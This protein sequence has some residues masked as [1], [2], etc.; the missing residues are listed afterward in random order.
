VTRPTL[1]QVDFYCRQAH[2]KVDALT[3]YL[4]YEQ[5]GW[6][7]GKTPMKNWRAAVAL[8]DRTQQLRREAL[9]V[10]KRDQEFAAAIKRSRED[11]RPDEGLFQF[12]TR[13]GA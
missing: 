6:F 11:D 9:N 2:P 10:S 12:P 5:K 4:F 13:S 7:V 8:W 1:E 3:F